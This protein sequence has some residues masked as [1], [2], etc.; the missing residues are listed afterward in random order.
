MRHNTHNRRDLRVVVCMTE[1]RQQKD[2]GGQIRHSKMYEQVLNWLVIV[3]KDGG[4]FLKKKHTYRD[5]QQRFESTLALSLSMILIYDAESV[6]LSLSLSVSFCISRVCW[7]ALFLCSL[8][9]SKRSRLLE[10][11]LL[12]LS[13]LRGTGALRVNWDCCYAAKFLEW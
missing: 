5:H 4:R 11:T 10:H 2:V 1:L 3:E 13:H 9:T 7:R 6:S 8:A 12:L